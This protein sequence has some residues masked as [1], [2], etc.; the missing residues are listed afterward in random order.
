MKTAEP[1]ST[2]TQTRHQDSSSP[3]FK[4]QGGYASFGERETEPEAFFKGSGS[5]AKLKVGGA[6]DAYEK[7]AE[8]TADRVVEQL[9]SSKSNSPDLGSTGAGEA[10]SKS[11]QSI[12]P[13]I[14]PKAQTAKPEEEIQKKE[15]EEEEGTELNVQR[16]PIFEN[17]DSIQRSAEGESPTPSSS[18]ES[19]LSS[20][21][22]G[23]SS[24]PTD[25][26][27]SMGEAM[28]ADLSGVRVHNDS[29]AAQMSNDL[30]AQAF[31]HGSDIYF[32]E[33]NY[34]PDTSDGQH[35]LAHE[36]TH[37]VQQGGS[38][39]Q[40]Q[41]AGEDDAPAVAPPRPT[42]RI[43]IKDRFNPSPAWQAYLDAQGETSRNR[44][45]EVPVKIGNDYEGDI[46]VRK[47][48]RRSTAN[49][50]GRYLLGGSR[51]G[52]HYLDAQGMTFFNPLRDAGV[53]PIL[54]LEAFGEEGQTTGFFSVRLGQ[55]VIG[56][57][58]GFIT[59]L[60]ENLEA[61]SFLG[62]QP[63]EVPGG[64]IENVF[65]NGRLV[66]QVNG[67]TTVVDGFLEIGGGMGIVGSNFTFNLN[68]NVDIEGLASGEFTLSR[69]ENGQL[70]GRANI[71][72]DIANV[73]AQILVEY[74]EG[75]VTIQGTGT[76]QSEKF[77]GS[78]TL[79]VTDRARST[80]M[81]HA[82]LG[83]QA[84]D[85]EADNQESAPAA[86]TPGNQ[87]LVAWGE[88]TATIT[89]WLEGSAKIGID[90]EGHV[91]IV[92]EIV[93][94]DEVEL[95]EQRGRKVDLFDVEIRAGY[96][97]PLVGQVFL[98]AS[99]GMFINAGFGPLVLRDIRFEGTYSTDPSI[100]QNFNITGTLALNAFAVLGLEAEAGV[101]L[102]LL[103]HDVKA[104][105]N[106]TAAAGLRAYALATPSF[107]YSESQAP[108]GG[109]VG[110]AHL[111]GHFE[112]AAQLFMQL[113]G[114]LFYE[115][116]SPWWSPAP[117][118]RTDH[119]LG[120]VQYPIGDSLGIGA[121]IDWLVGSPDVP[122][123]E[124][125]PIEFD[126]E[127]FTADVMADPPPNRGGNSDQSPE[128][129]W[130]D[131]ATTG[132][133]D[134][135]P[136]A[137][138]GGEGIPRGNQQEEN[139][140]NLPDEQKYMRGLSEVSEIK[141]SRE[142]P[143][144][145]VV[146][147]KLN[148]IKRRYGLN[149]VQI[150]ETN[151][152]NVKIFVSHARQDN[153]A[154]LVEVPIMS[155]AERIRLL[156]AAIPDLTTRMNTEA[157]EAGTLTQAQARTLSAA[158]QTA[159]PVIEGVRVVDGGDSWD[160]QVDVGDMDQRVPGK[161]KTGE[162]SEQNPTSNANDD[163]DPAE[164]ERQV[165]EGL[166]A[167]DTEERQYL[168]DSAITQENAE[169]VAET[170]KTRFPVFTSLTV[171]D[172]G[173]SWDYDYTASPGEVK[174][175]EDKK[176]E[177]KE[178][179]FSMNASNKS[180]ALEQLELIT[181]AQVPGIDATTLEYYKNGKPN[182]KSPNQFI[183]GY[184]QYLDASRSAYLWPL[185]YLTQRAARR[186]GRTNELKFIQAYFPGANKNNKSY[187]TTVRT[188]N[189][190]RPVTTIPDFVLGDAVGDV[191]DVNYQSYTEQ[192]RGIEKV[193]HAANYPN[194]VKEGAITSNKNISW[195]KDFVLIVNV[196]TEV[197]APLEDA[198][199]YVIEVDPT[200][201][202]E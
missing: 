194:E 120:D 169:Q 168:E 66:F 7:E 189:E 71:Q 91:T 119:P 199:S 65:E 113:S 181:A 196:N 138:G 157:G 192:L 88:V 151:D 15:T 24:L 124:F 60:N 135:D 127:Q 156:A 26:Q 25:T 187:S 141:N 152:D 184:K 101:G 51:A 170:V 122:E 200:A 5:Q 70:S 109:K 69:D 201:L 18:L 3:F 107:E 198:L 50:P 48:S 43:D 84:M 4:K 59:K 40:I 186:R 44:D 52:R 14:Q 8:Q 123:V 67:M 126:P 191:K 177:F 94:T 35:L 172:G 125:S 128:G 55:T 79:L 23:G 145:A 176:I 87:V 12:A 53:F 154:H 155:E 37:T 171:I 104:G 22:G 202:I 62:L 173:D 46:T 75:V 76:I 77:S 98:F 131:G 166:A 167:I 89:P 197:S 159:H 160:F 153:S 106:V 136:S 130:Q 115:L 178:G 133:L 193:A 105:V 165:Q 74:L 139:L 1:K 185:P 27:S 28:G 20:S 114:S 17:D 103:G 142:R 188:N 10:G 32:N 38:P 45:I 149:R 36:L 144:V 30:N 158:W 2:A 116:D 161:G 39:Q 121:D 134:A 72:A 112:A 147:S 108:E 63:L 19:Q 117:D 175:G 140:A 182:P 81:M 57:V 90:A 100:L 82:A 162:D 129:D 33:G 85:S 83:V 42:E 29:D 56:N 34:S 132:N 58:R 16:K 190:E 183:D 61:M 47:D 146:E 54:V 13:A 195:N 96:G 164:K 78:L 180:S 148:R 93:V 102:T 86:K 41:K 92:G 118:G 95:M 111:R 174:Q 110:E 143:T 97:I 80:Q 179:R 6:D 73:N 68:T 49:R 150:R 99:I 11:S 9:G 64:S 21:K 163:L 31:T 137:E